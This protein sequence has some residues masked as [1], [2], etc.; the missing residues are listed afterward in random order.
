MENFTDTSSGGFLDICTDT[1]DSE[2]FAS[3]MGDVLSLPG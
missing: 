3:L 1:K 2:H